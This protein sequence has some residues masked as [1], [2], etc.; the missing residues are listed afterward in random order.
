MTEPDDDTGLN[1]NVSSNDLEYAGKPG[2]PDPVV[3]EF[4]GPLDTTRASRSAA[5]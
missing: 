3:C 2:T 5:A 4:C 1:F